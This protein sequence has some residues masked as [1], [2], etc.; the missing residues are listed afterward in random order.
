MNRALIR[1]LSVLLAPLGAIPLADANDLNLLSCWRSQNM[2]QY[3]SD[4][5]VIHLNSDCI[6]EVSLK[7]IRT[8]CQNASGSVSNL[9][10][11]EI[12]AP[13]RYVTTLSEGSAAA[14][15]PPQPRP[16]EYVVDGEWLMLTTFPPKRANA[17]PPLPDKVVNL[18]VRVNAP[19]GKDMCHPRGPSKIRVGGGAVSSLLLTVPKTYAPVLKDPFDP[20]ADPHLR[21]AINS[22]FLI[23][24]FV[25]AGSEKAW[26]EGIRMQ[27][28][29]YVL[30]VE[31]YRIGSRPIRPAD[32]RQYKASV[33]HDMGQDKVSCDDEK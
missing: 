11:Y 4:G 7:Q 32:F 6:S 14:K 19:S 5:K 23:G 1:S 29:G 2:D 33:K 26:A 22:N 24:Q 27:G 8:E 28:G 30:V 20:L 3:Y 13:G 15:E 12:T 18:A 31:D 16:G 17:Q 25:P 10:T 21:Q 9:Y